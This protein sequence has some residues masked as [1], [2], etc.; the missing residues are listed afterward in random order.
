MHLL[1]LYVYQY[2][3]LIIDPSSELYYLHNTTYLFN[4]TVYFISGDD[5]NY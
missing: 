2:T 5:I 3:K 1:S 4:S